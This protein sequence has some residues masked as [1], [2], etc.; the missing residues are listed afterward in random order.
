MR[1][2]VVALLVACGGAQNP[3][4]SAQQPAAVAAYPALAWAPDAPSYLVA[5]P[6]VRAGQRAVHDLIDSFGMLARISPEDV[7]AAARAWIGVDPL[8]AEL[9]TKLGIDLDGGIAVFSEG[10][11]PTIVVHLAA[12][13]TTHAFFDQ[14]RSLGMH[15]TTAS[16][17]GAD[18][19]TARLRDGLDASWAIEG[20]W[21]W[22]HI[23]SASEHEVANAWFVH[24]HHRVNATWVDGLAWA[25]RLARD[26]KPLAGFWNSHAT[27][28]KLVEMM[29]KD[30]LFNRTRAC[31]ATL[32]AVD[33]VGITVDGDGHHADGKLSF[34]LGSAAPRIA[35]SILPPPAGFD[36]LAKNAPLALQ[37]NLDVGALT[38]AFAP[39]L[40]AFGLTPEELLHVGVRTARGVLETLDPDKPSGTGAVALDLSSRTEVANLLNE[41]PSIALKS[42]RSFGPYRGTHVSIPF[43]ASLDYVLDDHLAL[44][45]LGDGLLDQLVAGTP[46][47]APPL[48]AI[49][50]RPPGLPER[51]WQ[52]LFGE[53]SDKRAGEII[54]SQLT[55]WHDA[56]ISV[57]IDQDALVL[58]A[59]GNRR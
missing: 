16:V 32:E 34:A 55:K 49:D 50:V 23:A 37:W 58:D 13:A 48:V 8:G 22:F 4:H 53:L 33:R 29:D 57:S 28:A 25:T 19:S 35:A 31:V 56:H 36:T 11:S 2:C 12:P 41:I 44:A 7:S 30:Q 40:N 46:S 1:A 38:G 47:K 3:N 17:E 24:P 14:L 54:A 27:L 9:G 39:C 20:D 6:S 26:A 51:T 10:L 18:I 5:A 52:F 15:A 59:S 43:V 21:L 45:A 42:E